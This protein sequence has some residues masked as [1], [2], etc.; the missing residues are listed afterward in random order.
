MSLVVDQKICNHWLNAWTAP[1][2]VTNYGY[3]KDV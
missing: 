1:R 2:E 3:E